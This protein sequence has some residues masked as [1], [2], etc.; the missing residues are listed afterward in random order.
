MQWPAWDTFIVSDILLDC[1]AASSD[2]KKLLIRRAQF[3]G[4][5]QKHIEGFQDGVWFEPI[6]TSSRRK[7]GSQ[8]TQE[9]KN[10]SGHWVINGA[11][12]QDAV[13]KYE[14]SE[15]NK[16]RFCGGPGTETLVVSQSGVGKPHMADAHGG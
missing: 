12:T 5:Q 14:W 7:C 16:C 3:P 11:H 15:T 10:R 1:S 6:K 9:K 2:T 13:C 8:G 4:W